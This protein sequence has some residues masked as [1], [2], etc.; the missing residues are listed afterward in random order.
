MTD[1]V[2]L[3]RPP[4]L[5]SKNQEENTRAL[6]DWTFSVYQILESEQQI[7]TRINS[8][9][10]VEPLSQS[11]SATPTQVEIQAIQNKINELIAASQRRT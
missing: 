3:P 2:S 9:A 4:R 10:Q 11:I 8:I 7:T 1:F 6:L 5:A